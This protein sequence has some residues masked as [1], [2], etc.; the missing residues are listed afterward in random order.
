MLPYLM[1]HVQDFACRNDDGW[2]GMVE[3]FILSDIFF[4][5]LYLFFIQQLFECMT[6]TYQTSPTRK[7]TNGSRNRSVP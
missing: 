7:E 5:F 2:N 4:I 1:K 3:H 6:A